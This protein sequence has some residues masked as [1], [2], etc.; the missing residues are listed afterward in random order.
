[1]GSR[2]HGAPRVR[3]GYVAQTRRNRHVSPLP[4]TDAQSFPPNLPSALGGRAAREGHAPMSRFCR[5]G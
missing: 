1:M 4:L 5:N 3:A 2:R